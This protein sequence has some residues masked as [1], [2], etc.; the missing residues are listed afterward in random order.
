MVTD[1]F[2][3]N[4]DEEYRYKYI[5]LIDRLISCPSGEE[6]QILEAS[7]EL[8][9]PDLIEVM[10]QEAEKLQQQYGEKDIASWLREFA[11]DLNGFIKSSQVT[12]NIPKGFPDD[13]PIFLMNILQKIIDQDGKTETIHPFL[14]E[15]LDKLNETFESF[16]RQF[17][18]D[19]F[20]N[21]IQADSLKDFASAILN[22]SNF[23]LD[24]PFGSKS[25]KVEIAILGCEFALQIYTKQKFP[26]EWAT[27]QDHLASAY[28]E[29]AKGEPAENLELAVACGKAALQVF[30]PDIFP[31][32]WADVQNSLGIIYTDRI[33]GTK[34][35][36]LEL[37]IY[38]LKNALKIY[39]QEKSLE[40][41]IAIQNNLG[42]AYYR[43]F[44]G[45]KA[46]NLENAIEHFLKII[47][48]I[49]VG[50]AETF[51][52]D[53]ARAK[54]HLGT[55]YNQRIRGEKSENIEI[56]IK[57]FLDAI[58]VYTFENFPEWWAATQNNLASSYSM[59]LNGSLLTNLELSLEYHFKALQIYTYND[60]PV[61]WA[62]IQDNLG[63]TY[64]EISNAKDKSLTDI[65]TAFHFFK[66]ALLIY[67][68][69]KYPFNWAGT[70]KNIADTYHIMGG[71]EN[72]DL[73]ISYYLDALKVY[74]VETSP[75]EYADTNFN[76][77]IA[78]RETHNLDKAY[79]CL[80]TVI[81][82]IEVLRDEINIGS[83]E[84]SDKRKLAEQSN[85]FYK[86]TVETCLELS[87]LAE[88]FEYAER[89]KTRN[90][91]EGILT[92]SF[93]TFFPANIATKLE[94]IQNNLQGCQY[95]LQHGSNNDLDALVQTIKQLRQERNNLQDE[96]L[97]LG[98]GFKTEAF[99]Q[100]LSEN[101]AVMELY[102][103]S[104]CFLIFIATKNQLDYWKSSS[105]DLKALN[106]WF[107]KYIQDYNQVFKNPWAI[108]LKDRLHELARILHLELILDKLPN[109]CQEL[110]IIPHQLLHLLPFH[111]LPLPNNC[112]K[113]LIDYFQTGVRYAPSCQI[114]RLT[115]EYER[116]SMEFFFGIQNP[117]QDLTFSSL[118][119]QII[120]S[121]Q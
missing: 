119:V 63:I 87:K 26:Q 16:F 97:P 100:S 84:E 38:H 70:I 91:L 110:I 14:C 51:S 71:M 116:S 53:W 4:M 22:F 43:R 33:R 69:D 76:L 19:N 3:K 32:D 62:M 5:S 54:F 17:I 12:L 113:Y 10:L 107:D 121:A 49:D 58:S 28:R 60:F 72:L 41:W 21:L 35:E 25:I 90:L 30:D 82:T 111:A 75:V 73:A 20:S 64:I 108:S 81:N 59:R 118:Q 89:S 9:N 11:T 24:F 40:K 44:F 31:D 105:D 13:Y 93:D 66:K 52:K 77:G 2:I 98:F 114:L 27:I 15:N 88:A 61:A 120:V 112:N 94:Q 57:N 48:I 96:Y 55:I 8:L 34:A 83:K 104:D 80:T 67:S 99:C 117:T 92:R 68:Y 86:A 109:N 7:I 37:A 74:T 46:E 95:E 50:Y 6:F 29:R 1:N 78:Y 106:I 36:N 65:E 39:S 102:I 42:I 18:Y 23:L 103:L 115:Q 47:E 45:E 79:T 101:T 85:T 56:A